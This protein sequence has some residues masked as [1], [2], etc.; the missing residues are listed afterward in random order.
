M[1]L[2]ITILATILLAMG[3]AADRSSPPL[4]SLLLGTTKF[5]SSNVEDLDIGPLHS[6]PTLTSLARDFW[7]YGIYDLPAMAML[8]F[9]QNF[10]PNLRHLAIRGWSSF[11]CQDENLIPMLMARR[12]RLQSVEIISQDMEEPDD[13]SLAVLRKLVEDGMSIHVGTQRQNYI[14]RVGYIDSDDD[15]E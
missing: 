1:Q 13:E 14:Y 4:Q 8:A 7:E 10:L 11:L 9:A 3:F 5:T 6:L 2:N 15:Y 12:T